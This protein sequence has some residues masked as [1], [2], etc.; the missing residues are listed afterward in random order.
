MIA[1]TVV[2]LNIKVVGPRFDSLVKTYARTADSL[3]LRA[4]YSAARAI[5][6]H[7]NSVGAAFTKLMSTPDKVDVDSTDTRL[8]LSI[9]LQTL[10]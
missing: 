6:A 9:F 5:R 4:V 8:L 10:T 3:A 2:K 7:S 1:H